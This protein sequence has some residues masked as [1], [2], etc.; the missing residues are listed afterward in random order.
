MSN[1]KSAPYPWQ[2]NQ[3]QRLQKQVEADR[4][5]HALLICGIAGL[6][7]RHFAKTMAEYL[8]CQSPKLGLACGECRSCQSLLLGQYFSRRPIPLW[9]QRIQRQFPVSFIAIY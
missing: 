1:N 9:I 8:L 6:G 4:F 2:Q 7:K 5:P 3:W